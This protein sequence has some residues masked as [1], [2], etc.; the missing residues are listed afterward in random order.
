MTIHPLV[1]KMPVV[2]KPGANESIVF[3]FEG[4]TLTVC[5]TRGVAVD[6]SLHIQVCM[7]GNDVPG[8]GSCLPSG[9]RKP[10]VKLVRRQVDWNALLVDYG[11]APAR[12]IFQKPRYIAHTPSWRGPFRPPS[13]W[14]LEALL[15]NGDYS[16]R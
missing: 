14:G 2:M 9:L 13:M 12:V 3:E 11:L 16:S 5:G 7:R 10:E 4:K 8:T 1:A 15:S 6:P